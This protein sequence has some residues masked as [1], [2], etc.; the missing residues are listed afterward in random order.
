MFAQNG[1]DRKDRCAVRNKPRVRARAQGQV[2]V[3]EVKTQPFLP[4]LRLGFRIGGDLVRG[5]GTG[6]ESRA[7]L[8]SVFVQVRC[9]LDQD[10]HFGGVEPDFEITTDLNERSEAAGMFKHG[11]RVGVFRRHV[12]GSRNGPRGKLG[13]LDA[14]DGHEQKMRVIQCNV[15]DLPV[16]VTAQL[17]HLIPERIRIPHFRVENPD[18]RIERLIGA[19]TDFQVERKH[20]VKSI[21]SDGHK[22]RTGAGKF[23]VQGF[24][25]RLKSLG[26]AAEMLRGLRLLGQSI[27]VLVIRPGPLLCQVQKIVREIRLDN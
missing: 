12:P 23:L 20:H 3:D 26:R 8:K 14:G 7:A 9:A 13:I 15:I 4:G 1:K 22:R 27:L 2:K 21:R 10:G 25:V 16:V 24:I 5:I 6:H 18:A 17:P 11:E 19:T